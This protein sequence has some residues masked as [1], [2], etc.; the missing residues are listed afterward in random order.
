MPL[1]DTANWVGSMLTTTA[2]VADN[3]KP[4]DKAGDGN[5]HPL[6]PGDKGTQHSV[7]RALKSVHHAVFNNPDHDT[8]DKAKKAHALLVNAAKPQDDDDDKKPA[9]K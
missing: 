5:G 3:D 2:K 4:Q 7:F 8:V 6:M 1:N 9:K